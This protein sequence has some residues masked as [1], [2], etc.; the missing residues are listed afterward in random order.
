MMRALL[1]PHEVITVDR[2]GPQHSGPYQVQ[3]TVH[4]I[5]PWGHF[6]DVTMRRNDIGQL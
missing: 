4:V 1:E 3:G 2:I 5:T 6:M